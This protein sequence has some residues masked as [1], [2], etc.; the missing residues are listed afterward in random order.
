MIQKTAAWPQRASSVQWFASV[1][2][3][4]GCEKIPHKSLI[5]VDSA[6]PGSGVAVSSA[7]R[8]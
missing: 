5:Q 8:T 7:W 6:S 4:M 2:V 1:P 3:P